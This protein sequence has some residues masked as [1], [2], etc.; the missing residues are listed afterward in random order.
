MGGFAATNDALKLR[1][2]RCEAAESVLDCVGLTPLVLV[3]RC[4]PPLPG[5]EVFAKLE[6]F[7]PG[8]SLADRFAAVACEAG[9]EALEGDV[10]VSR[11]MAGAARGVPSRLR[12]RPSTS[13]A[14]R[15]AMASFG[16][17]LELSEADPAPEYPLAAEQVRTLARELYDQT[18][19]RVTHVVAHGGWAEALRQELA[20]HVPAVVGLEVRFAGPD[21]VAGESLRGRGGPVESITRA[22]AGEWAGRLLAEG[23]RAGL[24]S[25]LA[26]AGASRVANS[27]VTRGE[28]GMVV[29]LFPDRAPTSSEAATGGPPPTW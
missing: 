22:E 5:V 27:L 23:L 2:R 18:C 19:G 10:A 25:G 24:R 29:C 9:P 21:G 15:R 7:N 16:A 13:D 17:E 3:E 20:P 8:G 11:A 28:P 6:S 14:H 4:L 12:V 26:L 1:A